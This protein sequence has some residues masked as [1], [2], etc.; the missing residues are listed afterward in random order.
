MREVAEAMHAEHG[1]ALREVAVILPSHRAGLYL[2]EE[3]AEVAASALWSPELFTFPEFMERLGGVRKADQVTLLFDLYAVTSRDGKRDPLETFLSWAPAVLRDMSE[4]DAHLI[5]HAAFYR[6]LRAIED[7]ENWSLRSMGTPSTGQQRLMD[8]WSRMKE[9][10]AALNQRST[11]LG[12]GT[13]GWV[14]RTAVDRCAKG[15]ARMEWKAVWFVGVNALTAAQH[16]VLEHCR[17]V[18]TAHLAWDADRWYLDDPQQEA[19]HHLR[20]LI[21]AMGPGSVAPSDHLRMLDRTIHAVELPDALSQCWHAAALI[22]RMSKEERARTAIVLTDESLLMPLL[23]ALP[24]TAGPVNVT[25]GVLLRALPAAS[26]VEAVLALHQRATATAIAF[27]DLEALLLHPHLQR[28]DASGMRGVVERL[29]GMDRPFIPRTVITPVISELTP[30]I[31]TAINALITP[32]PDA[33]ALVARLSTA[34]DFAR[35]AMRT[36]VFAQE[37]LFHLAGVLQQVNARLAEHAGE[38]ERTDLPALFNL[39]ARNERIDF[40]GE[41]LAGLQIMGML[42]TRGVDHDRMIV[43]G[44]QEGLLPPDAAS[45]GWIPHDVRRLFGL[46]L[47][48]DSDAVAAY[49]F[50]RALQ[51]S[52]N[53]TLLCSGADGG[54]GR[55]RFI[56]QIEHELSAASRTTFTGS[57]VAISVQRNVLPSTAIVKDDAV[58]ARLIGR[59]QRGLS[60]SAIT[61][62]LR[63]PL[64]FWFTQVLRLEQV[65]HTQDRLGEDVLGSVVHDVLKHTYEPWTGHELKHEALAAT[66]AG[67]E[68]AVRSAFADHGS[69]DRLE[70]GQ[71]LLQAAMAAR[72]IGRF[73]R[74]DAE[75]CEDGPPIVLSALEMPLEATLRVGGT[76]GDITVSG[77]LDRVEQ[78]GNITWILDYKT[79]GA[80]QADLSFTDLSVL[81]PAKRYGIQL[82]CY[83][84]LWLTTHPGERFV[85]AGIIPLRDPS[86]MSALRLKI[87]GDFGMN[88]SQLPAIEG[89][90]RATVLAIIDP[91]EP[92]AHDPTSRHC[93][94][95][96]T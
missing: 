62:W 70:A 92:I 8:H 87:N 64:D 68:A 95:C 72:A 73:I 44:A 86:A 11:G 15:E 13:A 24:V 12:R 5:D 2:R 39:L 19:G 56:A 53:V 30:A 55:S 51:R 18:G 69:F 52:S 43:I 54:E 17:S 40:F 75:R 46:P 96:A 90:L 71:P 1:T 42:E 67:I 9:L 20:P 23:R 83:A 37:Q 58:M 74:H 78:R 22:T 10:H 33:R 31:A 85:H 41:P 29:R 47:G 81:P 45:S 94:F 4:V 89:S 28:T 48:Q 76:L 57:S 93:R 7:I 14:E 65:D 32:A 63:C 3:L 21:T 26:L 6:D 60:P 34:I 79:G 38:V 27:A 88:R 66:S 80:K 16:R 82:L 35:E 91:S 50:Y 49:S 59:L 25:M 77:I 84:W 36:D 61:T